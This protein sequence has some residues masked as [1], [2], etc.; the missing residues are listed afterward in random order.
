MVWNF[1]ISISGFPCCQHRVVSILLSIDRIKAV[2][3][4]LL[5]VAE[6][7]LAFLLNHGV[8]FT[9]DLLM[10]LVIPFLIQKLPIVFFGVL[11][12]G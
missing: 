1:N 8:I 6:F 3:K 7:S 10:I 5:R 11:K 12:Q 9:F 2:S 4:T